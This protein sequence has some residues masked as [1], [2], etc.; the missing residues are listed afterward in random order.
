MDRSKYAVPRTAA[1]QAKELGGLQRPNLDLTCAIVH[2]HA[3]GMFFAEQAVVKGSSWTCEVLAHLFHI[4]TVRGHLDMRDYEVIV[5]A[6][7]CTKEVKSNAVSRLLALLVSRRRVRRAVIHGLS[8]GHSHEDIDQ[9]FSL[10]S[11]FLQTKAE[12]HDPEA[13]ADAMAEFLANKPFRPREDI[14]IIER[15]P[16]ERL[17][18][19]WCL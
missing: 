11:S 2:G 9:G 6:D 8:T 4:L 13:F 3:V 19:R 1:L 14:R 5:Q 16:C 17:D 10:L 12:L 15:I 18:A 7:N